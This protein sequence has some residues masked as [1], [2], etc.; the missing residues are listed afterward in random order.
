MYNVYTYVSQSYIKWSSL[1]TCIGSKY[2][3]FFLF[4]VARNVYI[5]RGRVKFILP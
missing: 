1:G 5:R 4:P 3:H 2:E